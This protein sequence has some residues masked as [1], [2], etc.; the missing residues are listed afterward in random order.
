MPLVARRKTGHLVL[1]WQVTNDGHPRYWM[2]G[3]PVS[4]GQSDSDLVRVPSETIGH[5]A[6]IVAQSGSGKSFFLGRLVEE[7]LLRTRARC[8]IL[9]S[10]ADFKR[11]HEVAPV[12][13]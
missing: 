1:G 3:Q 10:N 2:T 11:I 4:G 12:G 8:L 5:H 7:I 6:V 9:D 13:L